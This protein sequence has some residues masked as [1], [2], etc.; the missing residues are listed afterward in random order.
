[1]GAKGIRPGRGT[2]R[3]TGELDAGLRACLWSRVAMRILM[4][5]GSFPAND[6]QELYEGARTIRWQD[7]LTVKTT[8]AVEATG[9][10]PALRHTHYTGLRIKDAIVDVLRDALGARPDVDARDPA[11]RVVAHLS[12]GSCDLSLD[13]A[14]DALFKR[15]YRLAPTKA[16][17]KETLAAAVLLSAGYDGALPLVDPMCGSGTIALEAALIAH[18]RAPGLGRHFAVER[19]PAYDATLASRLEALREEA[20]VTGRADAPPIVARDRDPEA[21]AATLE[22][23]RRLGLPVRAEEG[24]ARE[25][26]PF[27]SGGWIVTNPPYGERLAPGRK[28]LKSFF[29][30]LGQSWRGF[31]GHRIA[32]L[33][34]GPEFESAFGLRPASRRKLWNGPIECDLLR[35]DVGVGQPSRSS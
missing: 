34:G 18:G 5:L 2:V 32:V 27:D 9:T 14:G 33:A 10:T 12:R 6:E 13:L 26:R 30:Q 7:H 25:L 8:F 35:Y 15:G 23:A 4:P 20:R 11:V 3:F 28:N 22:N 19:W 16:S 17:L 31:A 29:W 24:D 21:V 1:M